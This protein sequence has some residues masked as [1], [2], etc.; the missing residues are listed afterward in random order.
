MQWNSPTSRCF[1]KLDTNHLRFIHHSSSDILFFM[2][3]IKWAV[4]IARKWKNWISKC[5][6]PHTLTIW[7]NGSCYIV[8]KDNAHE[9]MKEQKYQLPLWLWLAQEGYR[10][11]MLLCAFV[12]LWFST[13]GEERGWWECCSPSP[14]NSILSGSPVSVWAQLSG[15]LEGR[16]RIECA[17]GCES[18]DS[19]PGLH[20]PTMWLIM[21]W[22]LLLLGSSLL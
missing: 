6:T 17:G 7:S 22:C 8:N 20:W 9:V 12:S 1:F 16:S 11:F 19:S 14:H 2:K 5:I 15:G 13:L 4:C 3:K 10:Q 21:G 18:S